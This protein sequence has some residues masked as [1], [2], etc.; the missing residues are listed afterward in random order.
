M[1]V[2]GRGA[3]SGT[4]KMGNS[5]GSQYHT[6]KGAD[7]KP[8]VFGNIKFVQKN[9][10]AKETLM[11]TMTRGRVYVEVGADG[12]P[13]RIVYFDIDNK[14]IKQIDLAH[15]H[16]MGD[17]EKLRPHTHHGYEHNENDSPKSKAAYLTTEEQAL[18][19]RVMRIWNNRGTSL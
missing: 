14:R 2:G 11:E 1:V 17:G 4:S 13:K 8:M 6:V 5:Y 7:G 15:S 12:K 18:V 10:G 3:S 9:P 19:D 16:K